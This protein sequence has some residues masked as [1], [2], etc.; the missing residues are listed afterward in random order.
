MRAIIL[1]LF[2]T[3]VFTGLR[4]ETAINVK[5]GS[6]RLIKTEQEIERI[7]VI[8]KGTV[9]ATIV[10]QNELIIE[11]VREGNAVVKIFYRGGQETYL[12]EV[13]NPGK[14]DK[15]VQ[16]DVQVLEI[17]NG[18]SSDLGIDWPGLLSP[19]QITDDNGNKAPSGILQAAEQAPPLLAFGKFV[20]GP[21]YAALDFLVKKNKAKILAKPKLVTLNGKKANFLSG[22]EV[23]VARINERGMASVEWKEYGVSLEVKPEVIQ[24]GAVRAEMKASV[25]NLDYANAVSLGQGSGLMPAIRTR[26]AQTTVT[27]NDEETIVIAGL[28]VN[29]ES[30]VTEGVPL[31]SEIPVLGEFFKNTRLE[32]KKSELVIFVTP[33]VLEAGIN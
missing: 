7:E 21:V 17:I 26:S 19:P 27:L 12:I 9:S 29:E 13:K 4:A 20:R 24:G 22:G 2:M 25:S 10:S 30:K 18:D 31:L 11:G 8:K 3:L 16:L 6:S 5:K 23:P 28:I 15:L 33:S 32:N 14:G 1:F